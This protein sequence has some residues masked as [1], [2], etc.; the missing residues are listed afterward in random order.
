MMTLP[1]K[2]GQSCCYEFTGPIISF[3]SRVFR[4]LSHICVLTFAHCQLSNRITLFMLTKKKT[5]TK[6]E[7]KSNNVYHVQ[8]TSNH[9]HA[10]CSTYWH[11]RCNWMCE[12]IGCYLLGVPYKHPNYDFHRNFNQ[13]DKKLMRQTMR[14]KNYHTK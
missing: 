14:R 4:M 7:E 6:C 12:F 9:F 13:N 3:G 5:N 11:F 8:K 10:F 2:C 1:L